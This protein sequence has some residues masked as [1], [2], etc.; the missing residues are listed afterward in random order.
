[1]AT[2]VSTMATSAF[3]RSSTLLM[4]AV[5]ERRAPTRETPVGVV[6]AVMP[7]TSSGT[8]ATTLGSDWRACRCPA[9]SFAEKARTARSKRR[10]ALD[11]VALAVARDD[12]GGVSRGGEDDDVAPAAIGRPSRSAAG[13][14]AS[15]WPWVGSEARVGSAGSASGRVWARLDGR[16]AR[17]RS[18]SAW[19]WDGR[20]GRFGR[21]GRLGGSAGVG[22]GS[23]SARRRGRLGGRGRARLDGRFGARPGSAAIVGTTIARLRSS[24]RAA[25]RGDGACDLRLVGDFRRSRRSP[26]RAL[27]SGASSRRAPR[28]THPVVRVAHRR[29]VLTTPD[30]N[31]PGPIAGGLATLAADLVRRPRGSP[32]RLPS[33]APGCSSASCRGRPKRPSW[34]SRWRSAAT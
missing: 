34:R 10:S 17:R 16:V 14:P 20:G 27:D 1:M 23:A 24:E 26:R 31:G 28:R 18:G 21:C 22:R 15:G 29:R 30:P 11:A 32:I 13:P 33:R 4:F 12:G 8:T 5:A 9:S 6:W 7:M 3:T 25:K 19:R 2:P